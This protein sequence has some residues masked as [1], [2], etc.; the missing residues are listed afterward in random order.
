MG[1]ARTGVRRSHRSRLTIVFASALAIGLGTSA[2]ALAADQPAPPPIP[3]PGEVVPVVP[4]REPGFP[5][6][7]APDPLAIPGPDP[8]PSPFPAPEPDPAPI[9]VLPEPGSEPAPDPGTDPGPGPTPE[10]TPDPTPGVVDAPGSEPSS[11]DPS[12][13]PAAVEPAPQPEPEPSPE[14]EPAPPSDAE[15]GVVGTGP[16]VISAPAEPDITAGVEAAVAE[17][18]AITDVAESAT[19]EASDREP[20]PADASSSGDAAQADPTGSA[21]D[22]PTPASPPPQY[23]DDNSQYQ[24]ETDSSEPP[25]DAVE[26]ASWNWTWILTICNGQPTSTST[27][28]GEP[29]SRDWVWNWVWNWSCDELPLVTP[30][31][32][33]DAGSSPQGTSEDRGSGLPQARPAN[34]NVNVSVRILSPGEDGPVVQTDAPQ[35]DPA[36]EPSWLWTWS[37]DWCGTTTEFTTVGGGGTGLDWTWNWFWLWDCESSGVPLPPDAIDTGGDTD[38]TPQQAP[39]P[40]PQSSPVESATQASDSSSSVPASDAAPSAESAVRMFMFPWSRFDTSTTLAPWWTP[41]AWTPSA[42]PY[43]ATPNVEIAVELPAVE[44]HIPAMTGPALPTRASPAVI[45]FSP[46]GSVAVVVE[47]SPVVPTLSTNIAAPS[48]WSSPIADA[49]PATGALHRA[50]DSVRTRPRATRAGWVQSTEITPSAERSHP[51]AAPSSGSSPRN[52]RRAPVPV[53]SSAP[54]QAGGA[55]GGGGSAPS[56]L[57][58]GFATLIGFF[59]FAAPGL[60][61]RIRLARLPSPRD[62]HDSPLDRPG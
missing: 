59:V 62:R 44:I 8:V 11:P 10:P 17:L 16:D 39:R 61:R 19:P 5:P 49:A 21:P 15:T 25:P 2:P 55:A 37:F 52:H 26:T 18:P 29:E 48:T 24:S 45:V 7:P 30:H 20:T 14:P 34:T 53:N 23:Q 36:A 35:S 12:T 22:P 32:E 4:V 60:G 27:E 28:S 9:P 41:S 51:S 57:V 50:P 13:D 1:A 58:F 40:R 47:I 31:T 38:P 42:I 46:A 56:L 43:F 6:L 54:L 3:S 33:S